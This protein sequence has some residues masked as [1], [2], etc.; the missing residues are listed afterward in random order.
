MHNRITGKLQ[1]YTPWSLYMR[2]D[3]L[4]KYQFSSYHADRRKTK[5]EA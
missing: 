1:R 5:Q 2:I 3:I 4:I